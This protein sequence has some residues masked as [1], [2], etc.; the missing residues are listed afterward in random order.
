[1]HARPG[2][3]AWA[4]Q[5]DLAGRSPECAVDVLVLQAVALL[6]DEEGQPVRDPRRASRR[7]A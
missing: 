4:P 6:G 7:S 5:P 3:I 1:M 2:M